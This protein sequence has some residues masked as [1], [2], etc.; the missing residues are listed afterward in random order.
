V[1]RII[2]DIKLPFTEPPEQA[3]KIALSRLGNPSGVTAHIAKKAIDARR[4]KDIKF[5][6]SVAVVGVSC[7]SPPITANL[8]AHNASPCDTPPV[9]AGF[10]PAGMFAGLLLARHG[11][12]PVILERGGEIHDRIEK[13]ENFWRTGKL[14]AQTNAQFGEGGAGTFSDGKLNTRISDPRCRFVLKELKNHGAPEEILYEAKPHIGTDKLR[15]I[16]S[17]I[18]EEIISLGGEVKFNTKM[19]DI[20]SDKCRLRGVITGAGEIP[21]ETLLL[22]I[23]HSARDTFAMLHEHGVAMSPKPFSVGVRIEHL[24]ADIDR[25]LYGEMAG[26]P[27]LPP[28]EYQLSLRRAERAVYTFC[29]CPGGVVVP[30]ASEPEALVTNGM[31]EFARDKKNANSALVVSVS[32]DDFGQAGTP[33]A[34]MEF[35]RRLEQAAFKRG[36]ADYKAPIQTVS[37]FRGGSGSLNRISPSYNIGVKDISFTDIFPEEIVDML[38]MG[39]SAFGGKLPGFDAPDAVLTALESR[40]SSPV[41]ILRGEDMQS[42]THPGLYPCGE[43]AGYAGGIMS[44]AVDGVAAAQAVMKIDDIQQL[45]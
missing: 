19:A 16:V 32:P 25:A 12:R 23:G 18:R 36:G 4:Q 13:V 21:A 27:L 43:G 29:M 3:V 33:L 40:T 1:N 30:A 35:Q 45:V 11:Y 6:Y 31:S 17:S 37:A 39:L 15:K 38:H 26:H 20:I 5:V 28:G 22:A 14:D 34:G 44:A 42:V 24:Q 10:G 2:H 8:W 7:A 9:I 41:R